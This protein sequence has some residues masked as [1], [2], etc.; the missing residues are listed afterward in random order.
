MP[1]FILFILALLLS[2]QGYG[3]S[4][5]PPNI[6]FELGNLTYWNFYI[7]SCCPISTPN[8]S[9]P[10]TNR[11]TL[12][13]GSANDPYGGFPIVSPYGGNYSL[14]LG[15]DSIGAQ[16][17]KARYYIHIPSGISNY[18]LIYR[19][20]IVLQNPNHTAAQ[21]PRYDVACYDSITSASISCNT[22][23]YVASGSLPGFLQS[24]ADTSVRYKTWTTGMLNLSGYSGRT[25]IVD[26][27]TGDCSLGGHFGYGYL[28]MDCGLFQIATTQCNL[29]GYTNLSAP[30]GF[31]SYVWKD[32]ALTTTLGTTQNITIATPSVSKTYKVIMT[33]FAG[34]GCPDTLTTLLTISNL[35]LSLTHDTAICAGS[36]VALQAGISGGLSPITVSW[37]PSTGL[38]CNNCANPLATPLVTTKYFVTVTDSTGCSRHDSVT[39]TIKPIPGLSSTLNPA[40]ICN[41]T[42]FHYL[43]TTSASGALF[44]W[45]R[46]AI[47]G[48]ANPAA[49]GIDSINEVLNNTTVNPINVP[50]VVSITANGC[51]NMQ[52]VTVT[53]FPTPTLSSPTTPPAICNGTAFIYYPASATQNTSFS[54]TRATVYGISNTAGSGIG[55]INETLSDTLNTT[56]NVVYHVTLTANYCN[57]IQDVTVTVKPTPAFTSTLSPAAICNNTNFSYTPASNV[58]GATFTW[59]RAAVVGISNVAATGSGSINE[60]LHN[61]TVNPIVVTYVYNITANGCTNTATIAV[62]VNPTPT[63][64]SPT[65]GSS[66]CNGLTFS[67]TA[68]SATVNTTFAWTRASMYGLQNAAASGTGN[69]NEVLYDTLNT[70]ITV[71]YTYI[72]TANGCTDTQQVQV[73]VNPTPT[74]S[75]T[76]NPAS[77]CSNTMFSYA[78]TSAITNA[79]TT[80]TWTRAVVSGISNAAGSGTGAINEILI[81]TTN[82]PV[83]VAYVFNLS[84]N[85]CQNSQTVHVVVKPYAALPTATYNN[86]L[87][88]GDTLYLNSQSITSGVTYSWYGPGGY[89]SNLQNPNI[90]NVQTAHAGTYYAIANLNGCADTASVNVAVHAS[91]GAPIISISVTPGDTACVGALLTFTAVAG[92]A[93]SQQYQWMRN[94]ANIVGATNVTYSSLAL[95]NGDNIACHILSNGVCQHIDTAISNTIHL[96]LQAYPPPSIYVTEYTS[97]N[98]HTFTCHVTGSTVN[99]SYQWKR[100]GQIIPGATNSFY[101]SNLL[102][103]EDSICVVVHSSATCTV[104][105]SSVACMTVIAGINNYISYGEN[106]SIY[107]NP[108]TNELIIEGAGKGDAYRLLNVLGQQ[109]LKGNIASKLHLIDTHELLPGNY[110]L[111]LEFEDGSRLQKKIMK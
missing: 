109:V 83:T 26:F 37:T 100:N 17:E 55:N 102:H 36:S 6:D 19:Y 81:N 47:S 77:I 53:V 70:S 11:H 101:S 43:P 88:S 25:V 58:S 76:L 46:A 107:P 90:V 14:R 3:Q 59:N 72:L 29:G 94:G 95:S 12:T 93:Y 64:S 87:C 92:N 40:G 27:A 79:I 63:L 97:G 75:S 48:I 98:T 5:C 73:V 31:Q 54:W 105:D 91:I 57:N 13:S 4:A 99:L 65:N 61:T 24:S 78:A 96:T 15:N 71:N 51:T 45:T 16:A 49:N 84:A 52:T 106:I 62:T 108:V 86:P 39:V 103:S 21:Q 104:P 30:S 22:F 33:P 7:G 80:A 2:T 56:V 20:A 74:L 38:S 85:G 41:N 50:Y 66:I 68:T 67:Y 18:A 1:R 89:T 10:V 32:S 44:S 42:L 9:G 110:I 34:Y 111:E 23:S 28:D 8:N 82:A 35:G 60:V 69:I